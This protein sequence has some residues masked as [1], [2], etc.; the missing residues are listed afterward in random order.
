MKRSEKYPLVVNAEDQQE[1]YQYITREDAGW[2]Y[3][4]FGARRML[5]G[6]TWTVDTLEQEY[7]IILLG[8][9]YIVESDCGSW[10]TTNGRRDVFS[11]MPHVLY[12]P[13]RTKFTLTASSTVLD[14]AYGWCETDKDFAPVFK[15]PE[16]LAVEIRGGDNASRQI[17]DLLGPGFPCHRLVVVEV[18]TPSGNWSSFPAHKHDERVVD[19]EGELLEARLE[20]TYFYKVAKPQGYAMQRVYT[21]DGSLDEVAI[22]RN[23]DVVMVPRGYHPVVAGHGYDVYYLNFLAGSDQSLANTPDPEHAW[24]FDTWTGI[25]DRLPLVSAIMNTLKR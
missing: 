20:E 7:A 18:Y 3:L 22:A 17:N 21:S 10:K 5:A 8:G 24:I 14:L 19:K 23:N 2:Q 25:D 13:R 6:E 11:G 16:E 4:N 1:N 15:K 9:D 12:L